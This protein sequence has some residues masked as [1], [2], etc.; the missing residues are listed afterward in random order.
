MKNALW[1]VVYTVTFLLLENL[2]IW[3]SNMVM[4][5]VQVDSKDWVFAPG[6]ADGQ[7]PGLATLSFV[8]HHQYLNILRLQPSQD[9]A[10]QEVFWQHLYWIII[11]KHY[12]E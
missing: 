2:S 4:A 9:Q 11:T 10:K 8:G 1:L 3:L 12:C 7:C 5:E 6:Q